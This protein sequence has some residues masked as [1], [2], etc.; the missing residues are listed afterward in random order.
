MIRKLFDQVTSVVASTR[1]DADDPA[2]R[3]HALDLATACLMVEVARADHSFEES[4]FDALL[5]L[6]ERHLSLSPEEANELANKAGDHAEDAVDVHQ[7]TKK[8]HEH[9][10]N[11]EKAEVV[12]MLWRVAYADGRL[13][14]FE[15]SLVLKIS[16]LLYVSR[17]LVMRL[18]HDAETAAR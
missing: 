16:D 9:M 8:L 15:D 12:S 5:R 6:L 13:D 2:A 7:F 4:E 11:A 14:K 10:S 18:K 1:A 3:R 17:G